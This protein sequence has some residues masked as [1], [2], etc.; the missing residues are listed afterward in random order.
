MYTHFFP[1]QYCDPKIIDIKKA[2]QEKRKLG[3][4]PF[5]VVYSEAFG[6]KG[7]RDATRAKFKE[8]K[9]SLQKMEIK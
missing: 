8:A 6:D 2:I 7:K 3:S 5:T 1:C 4:L 9:I